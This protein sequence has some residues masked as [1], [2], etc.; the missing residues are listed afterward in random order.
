[1]GCGHFAELDDS[2]KR[3]PLDP[4]R[5]AVGHRVVVELFG[6]LPP[7][8]SDFPVDEREKWL[9]AVAAVL[10]LTHGLEDNIRIERERR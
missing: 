8:G 5:V 9:R 1:M 2:A 7:L 10:V 3:K 6:M 4:K